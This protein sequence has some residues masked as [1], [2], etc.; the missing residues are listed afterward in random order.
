MH[1]LNKV[2]LFGPEGKVWL[3]RDSGDDIH[4]QMVC[5]GFIAGVVGRGVGC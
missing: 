4:T 5:M 2:F 1:R 3:V